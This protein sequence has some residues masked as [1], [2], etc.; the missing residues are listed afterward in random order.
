MGFTMTRLRLG[1]QC[2]KNKSYQR[3]RLLKEPVPA[4]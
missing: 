2:G 4:T 1:Q 3:S